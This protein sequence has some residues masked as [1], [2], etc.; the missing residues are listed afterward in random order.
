[1]PSLRA[2]HWRPEAYAA[3]AAGPGSRAWPEACVHLAAG[4]LAWVCPFPS[5]PKA[6]EAEHRAADLAHPH[7]HS[8]GDRP[9]APD[10]AS[11][12]E[13]DAGETC[14]RAVPQTGGTRHKRRPSTS[15]RHNSPRP[16][17]RATTDSTC[18]N[19]PPAA[20]A[21]PNTSPNSHGAATKTQSRHTHCNRCVP[22]NKPGERCWRWALAAAPR[23]R[24]LA[25]ANRRAGPRSQAGALLGAGAQH[26]PRARLLGGPN[27]AK[28]PHL[29]CDQTSS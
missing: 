10:A 28:S 9:A 18:S 25:L 14:D 16:M 15:Q 7:H 26:P 5:G 27:L 8:H 4:S 17:Y 20:A 12:A 1:M 24:P 3:P 11:A 29:R 21:G 2:D 6:G 13:N 23:T 19:S 22:P